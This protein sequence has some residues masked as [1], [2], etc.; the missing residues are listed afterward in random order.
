M[1]QTGFSWRPWLH[2]PKDNE[3]FGLESDN[4]LVAIAAMATFC[5][6]GRLTTLVGAD[7]GAPQFPEQ[8]LSLVSR[9][10]RA[11]SDELRIELSRR[12]V[13]KG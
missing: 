8:L 13:M 11:A 2:I 10:R 12:V 9:T 1:E 5:L 4:E 3:I 6:G 7:I